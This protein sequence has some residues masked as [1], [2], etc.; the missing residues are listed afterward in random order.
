MKQRTTCQR[1]A[2][3]GAGA[4]PA[5]AAAGARAGVPAARRS[6]SATIGHTR[7][8]G[9]LPSGSASDASA[10][11]ARW[12][13]APSADDP[14]TSPALGLPDPAS[15]IGICRGGAVSAARGAREQLPRPGRAAGE[16]GPGHTP[17]S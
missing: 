10:A 4:G 16:P 1:V 9:E 12:R 14:R 15:P 13:A 6:A 11:R 3:R 5:V 2:S 17:R 8:T 7:G